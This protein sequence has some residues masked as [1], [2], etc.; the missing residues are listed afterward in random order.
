MRARGVDL[1]WPRSM[2]GVVGTLSERSLSMVA[3]RAYQKDQSDF[4]LSIEGTSWAN[5]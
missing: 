3:R 5:G 4:V 2:R 1:H